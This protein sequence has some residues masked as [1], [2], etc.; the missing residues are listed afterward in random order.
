MAR[1]HSQT[2]ANNLTASGRD[3][4]CTVPGCHACVLEVHHVTPAN[5]G[6]SNDVEN[7]V[8]VCRQHHALLERYYFWRRLR[9]APEA[10][11]EIQKIARAFNRGLVPALLVVELGARTKKLWAEVHATSECQNPLWWQAG[12]VS[13]VKWAQT[14]E[15]LRDVNPGNAIIEEPWFRDRSHNESENLYDFQR[16]ARARQG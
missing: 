12:F 15:V 7:L 3:R 6:G 9:V 8:W 10:C 2:L 5:V 14:Q 1:V 4:V 16:K 11:K 13:A